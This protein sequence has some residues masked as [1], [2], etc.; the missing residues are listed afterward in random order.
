MKPALS[1]KDRFKTQ[2]SLAPRVTFQPLIHPCWRLLRCNF[3]FSNSLP[4]FKTVI[5]LG[6]HDFMGGRQTGGTDQEDEMDFLHVSCYRHLV[7]NDSGTKKSGKILAGEKFFRERRKIQ[8]GAFAI[9]FGVYVCACAHCLIHSC[10]SFYVLVLFSE[11]KQSRS[12]A[13]T[14]IAQTMSGEGSG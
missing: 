8:A 13:R 14:G 5:S 6:A 12:S 9:C 1:K 4:P 7:K 2:T 11:L 10:S 3:C